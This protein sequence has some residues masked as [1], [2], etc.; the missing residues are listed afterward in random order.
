MSCS[1]LLLD[2]HMVLNY[3]GFGSEL[4]EVNLMT[5]MKRVTIAMPSDLDAKILDMKKS[6]QYVRTSYSEIVRMLLVRGLDGLRK[7]TDNA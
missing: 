1:E 2:I 3:N 6:D 4:K 7:S 5:D